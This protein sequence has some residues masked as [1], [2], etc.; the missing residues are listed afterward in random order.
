MA[1]VV[2]LLV[3]IVRGR[4]RGIS[5]ELLDVF[6]WL[7]VVAVAGLFYRGT[8]EF[9]MANSVFSLLSC[10]LAG[11]T[12]LALIV[13]LVFSL[14]QRAIGQKLAGSDAFGSGE[15]YL[16]MFGGMVRYACVVLVVI[17]LVN[18]RYYSPQEIMQSAQ[19][20]RDEFG[21]EFLPTFGELRQEVVEHSLLGRLVTGHL[22]AVMIQPT[23]PGERP[24][25]HEGNI[26]KA[27]ERQINQVLENKR[28]LEPK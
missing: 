23:A 19:Y 6:K 20:Q 14:V 16:G 8:G 26:V 24:L 11:Y 9:L 13:L 28:G 27:R 22:S 3:G 12:L 1:I 5:Q 4:Q 10:Y 21:S 7:L 25:V 18:A 2:V 17:S 15:Y